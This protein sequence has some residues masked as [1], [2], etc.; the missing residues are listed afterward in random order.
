[1]LYAVELEYQP[2]VGSFGYNAFVAR[3]GLGL[4]MGVVNLQV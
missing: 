1:M 2:S 4:E 3:A